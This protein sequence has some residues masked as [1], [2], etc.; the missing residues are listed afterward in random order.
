M[1]GALVSSTGMPVGAEALRGADA[2]ELHPKRTLRRS[3]ML[4]AESRPLA[5][6]GSPPNVG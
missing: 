2:V 4:D 6:S 3:E 5:E 1:Q